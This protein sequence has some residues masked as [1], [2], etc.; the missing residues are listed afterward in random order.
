MTPPLPSSSRGR[1]SSPSV[2]SFVRLLARASSPLVCASTLSPVT[3]SLP[4]SIY[5]APYLEVGRVVPIWWRRTRLR[6]TVSGQLA[7]LNATSL[8][9]PYLIRKQRWQLFCVFKEVGLVVIL[10]LTDK[11]E[12]VEKAEWP[13]Y[14]VSRILPKNN[15][16]KWS[17]GEDTC[18]GWG[19]K[20]SIEESKEVDRRRTLGM[21][22]RRR[23][24][25]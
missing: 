11:Q 13:S 19:Q 9:F 5:F 22:S 4:L 2:Y 6:L 7:H 14:S 21:A 1:N 23:R 25:S 16:A 12:V 17:E 24:R 15:N 18:R 3:S 10:I 8:N 20:N